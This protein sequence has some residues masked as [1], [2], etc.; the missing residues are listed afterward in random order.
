MISLETIRQ[1]VKS[2]TSHYATTQ[3]Y[4]TELDELINAN[5][6]SI[7]NSMPWVFT[8]REAQLSIRPDITSTTTTV[9]V[10]DMSRRVTFSSPV[11]ELGYEFYHSTYDGQVIELDGRD[12]Y[13]QE[14]RTADE[15]MLSEPY[16]GTALVASSNWKIKHPYYVLPSDCQR[17]IGWSQEDKPILSGSN[18]KSR[19]LP[20][21]QQ[22]YHFPHTNVST[23][24]SHLFRVDNLAIPAGE[25]LSISYSSTP[26]SNALPLGRWNEFAWSFKYRDQYGPLS[27]SLVTKATG[28]SYVTAVITCIDT[29]GKQI[30]VPSRADELRPYPNS[31]EGLKKVLWFNA[32]INPDAT[33]ANSVRTGL[34]CWKPVMDFQP[35]PGDENEWRQLEIDSYTST[36]SISYEDCLNHSAN[37]NILRPAASNLAPPSR[38]RAHDIQQVRPYPRISEGDI[39]YSYSADPIGP[40][41]LFKKVIIRYIGRPEELTLSTDPISLPDDVVDVLV[42]KV[43]VD[44][45]NKKGDPN[46]ATFYEVKYKNELEAMKR[47]HL[48]VVTEDIYMGWW[49]YSAKNTSLWCPTSI[50]QTSI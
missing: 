36:F 47:N 24:A 1:R 40:K 15:I 10:E 19:F 43:L 4:N 42:Y 23:T 37:T 18:S 28:G 12:Y 45:F 13:I 8:Y 6:Q 41:E 49:G 7:W 34:P 39:T 11:R 35:S 22:S 27:Q 3:N 38:W 9:S 2:Q 26:N 25:K 14:V 30:K 33:S 20:V 44:I 16:R 48:S 5:H 29:H 31:W 21:T 32:N 50:I 46:M 17:L